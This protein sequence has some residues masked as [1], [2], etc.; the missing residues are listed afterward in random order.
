[1]SESGLRGSELA[2]GV[3][4]RQLCVLLVVQKASRP[5]IGHPQTEV[6]DQAAKQFGND[7]DVVL[8]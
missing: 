7:H 3:N 2:D 4:V 6:V 5:T 1:M 8:K